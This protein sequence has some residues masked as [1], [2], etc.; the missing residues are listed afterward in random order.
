MEKESE[1]HTTPPDASQEG[2]TFG[3]DRIFKFRQ[4]LTTK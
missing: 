4:H 1:Q 2:L 3:K